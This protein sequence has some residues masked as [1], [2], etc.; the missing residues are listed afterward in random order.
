MGELSLIFLQPKQAAINSLTSVI[1]LGFQT[2]YDNIVPHIKQY[3]ELHD[4]ACFSDYI[5]GKKNLC[6]VHSCPW[7]RA[8]KEYLFILFN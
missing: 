3:L 4:C 7:L 8:G 1:L 2:S 6:G 5:E